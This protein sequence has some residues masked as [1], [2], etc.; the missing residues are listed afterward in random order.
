MET[1]I[2]V[3]L[4][5][6]RAMEPRASADEDV[7]GKPFWTIVARRRTA[8]GSDVIVPIWTSRRYPDF[9][10]DLGLCFGSVS[11]EANSGNSS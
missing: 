9:D 8:I 5:V 1:V 3:A 2:D 10:A 6:A 11:G 4:E 7:T